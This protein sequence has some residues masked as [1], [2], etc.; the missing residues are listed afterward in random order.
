M[1]REC[2]PDYGWK[3]LKSLKDVFSGYE[4]R[5][6]GGTALALQLG[7]RVS[8]DLD[9]FTQETFKTESVISQV[10]KTGQPF[11][12]IAEEEGMLIMD[13]GGIRLSLFTYEYNFLEKSI[14][15][16]SVQLAGIIDIASMKVIAINQRGSKRDFVDL[17]FVLQDIPFHKIATNM[18]KRFGAER[19]NP[20]HIGKSFVYFSDADTNPEPAYI[21][22][23]E[24]QWE[25]IKGFFRNHV[26][27]FVL[28]LEAAT[29]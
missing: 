17:Y 13:V 2:F 27:Q 11:T 23:R 3:V 19:I 29:R 4:A 1:H 25:R 8:R 9:F 28:D 10:R 26:R 24:V 5:L 18:V 7:H 22:G 12:V 15:V 16:H 20:V 6:A 14:R 21:K